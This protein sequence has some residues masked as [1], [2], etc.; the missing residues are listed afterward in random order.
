MS[1]QGHARIAVLGA[2]GVS[3]GFAF[4]QAETRG[5]TPLAIGRNP[6]KLEAFLKNRGMDPSRMR[7]ADVHD[8][9][10]LHAALDGVNAVISTVAPFTTNG[11]AVAAAAAALG[12][13]YTDSS[14]EGAFVQR[15]AR[16]LDPVALRTGATLCT[17]NGAAAFL[18]DIA[19][20]WL[21]D[22]H[23]ASEGGVLYDIRGYQPT[24]GTLRSYLTSIMPT[25]GALIREGKL[26]FASFGAF[27]GHVAGV[28]GIHSVLPDALVVS[29]YWQPR[30]FDA[31][32]KMS[33]ALRPVVA[34]ATGLLTWPPMLRLLM[35]LPLERWVPYDAARPDRASVTAFAEVRSGSGAVRR[36]AV[37]GATV[38]PLTGAVL[39]ATAQAMMSRTKR[40]VGVRAA[41]EMFMSFEEALSL[42]GATEISVPAI[43]ERDP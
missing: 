6:H 34:A 18:G 37:T 15:V 43:K 14:G 33:P 11:F 12:L 25:G 10:A 38:Y 2:T 13:A 16:E 20:R 23:P 40:P 36:R 39:A 29:R 17:G 7:V 26:R 9:A 1:G 21:I 5:L 41:S 28:A 42:S 4:D 30:T 35:R 19:I 3:G 32:F 24:F 22:D 8:Q 31:L 27:N